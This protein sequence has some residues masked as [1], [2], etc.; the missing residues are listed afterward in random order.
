MFGRLARAL[1]FLLLGWFAFIMG[2]VIYAKVM[3]RDSTT[4]EPDADDIDLVTTFGPLEYASTASSF[5]GGKVTTWFG[6]GQ[7][8]LRGATL[9]PAGATLRLSTMFGGG[10][11]IVPADWRVELHIAPVF[12]GIGDARPDGNPAEGAPTLRLEGFTL[13]GGW[14]VTTEAP[15][16]E[17]VTA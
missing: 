8:D 7:L 5:R 10:N 3:G 17:L 1:S 9:D 13:F 4:P 12:G 2:A 15:G 6:G 16:E 11:L 14:G